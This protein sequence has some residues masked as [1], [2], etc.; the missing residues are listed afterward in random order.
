MTDKRIIRIT[1]TDIKKLNYKECLTL[2]E[3]LRTGDTL[4]SSAA[5]PEGPSR[6]AR[7]NAL[8]GPWRGGSLRFIY[9]KFDMRFFQGLEMIL[10][11]HSAL[12]SVSSAFM[13]TNLSD[14]RLAEADC[15]GRC[16]HPELIRGGK[17]HVVPGGPLQGRAPL[18]IRC[19]N[20]DT[21]DGEANVRLLARE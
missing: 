1:I 14:V 18:P 12:I 21:L 9:R 13:K 6:A 16:G 4:N 20:R 19:S 2:T 7:S 11:C 8:N 3:K 10:P 15:L 5:V 17:S